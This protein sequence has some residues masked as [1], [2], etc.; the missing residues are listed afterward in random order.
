MRRAAAAAL[1]RRASCPHTGVVTPATGRS[2]SDWGRR[3]VLAALQLEAEAGQW[4]L[5]GAAARRRI[6]SV[7]SRP[8]SVNVQVVWKRL[9]SSSTGGGMTDHGGVVFPQEHAA[10]SQH[11]STADRSLSDLVPGQDVEVWRGAAA[12]WGKARV[13]LVSSDKFLVKFDAPAVADGSVHRIDGVA[14]GEAERTETAGKVDEHLWLERGSAHARLATTHE[15]GASGGTKARGRGGMYTGNIPDVNL[16]VMNYLRQLDHRLR[17]QGIHVLRWFS[18][19]VLVG[20]VAL[21]LFYVIFAEDV[22]SGLGAEGAI[23]TSRT[24]S[25]KRVQ[26]AAEVVAK[27]VALELLR[28]PATIHGA[29]EFV[30]QVGRRP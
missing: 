27:E 24:I 15:H 2:S 29:A 9:S 11:I 7:R 18:G 6:A 28:N 30:K 8:T 22:R 3:S 14:S 5:N 1:A 23:V 13:V 25:D 20:A 17:F 4:W 10:G 19:M 16:E 12:G 21:Y 26:D